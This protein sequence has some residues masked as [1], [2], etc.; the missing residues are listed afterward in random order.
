C[1][2]GKGLKS[3]EASTT[4]MDT[5]TYCDGD[6]GMRNPEK[7]S[8]YPLTRLIPSRKRIALV[9]HD[10]RKEQ[11]ASWALKHRT[12][13]IEHELYAT[14]HTADIIA[15][16]LNAPVFRFL[17]GFLGVP[18]PRA[19]GLIGLRNFCYIWW[20]HRWDWQEPRMFT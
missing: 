18:Y 14:S 11:L 10:N 4:I 3:P 13:L 2:T 12:R 6:S 9:A 19:A 5:M 16:A 20:P 17:R 8:L 1:V 7:P 15:E